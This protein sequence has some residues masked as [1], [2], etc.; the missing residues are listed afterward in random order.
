M[1]GKLRGSSQNLMYA[2]GVRDEGSVAELEASQS[3]TR[4]PRSSHL[5][6]SPRYSQPGM[7]EVP[8]H[9]PRMSAP[10]LT[11]SPRWS[12]P[13]TPEYLAAASP[14]SPSPSASPRSPRRSEMLFALAR[15]DDGAM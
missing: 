5:A 8:A 14:S 4:L 12:Q 3:S 9:L 7:S 2:A 6:Q 11:P 1:S 10:Q 15:G 13:T